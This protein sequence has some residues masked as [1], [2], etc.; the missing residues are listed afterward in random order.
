MEFLTHF[1]DW[2]LFLLV[3]CPTFEAFRLSGLCAAS[4]ARAFIISSRAGIPVPKAA[5]KA[6]TAALALGGADELFKFAP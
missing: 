4:L 6:G 5:F 3:S 2:L 1:M